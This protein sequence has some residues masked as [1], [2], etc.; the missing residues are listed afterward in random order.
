MEVI[1]TPTY[2]GLKLITAYFNKYLYQDARGSRWYKSGRR[3]FL[4]VEEKKKKT[5]AWVEVPDDGRTK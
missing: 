1:R 4:L 5:I 3:I 2:L